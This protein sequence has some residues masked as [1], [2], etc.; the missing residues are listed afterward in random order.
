[1]WLTFCQFAA[2]I[3]QTVEV[4]IL[5][6]N[7]NWDY[8]LYRRSSSN[9]AFFYSS[10]RLRGSSPVAQG[11]SLLTSHTQYSTVNSIPRPR[12]YGS[13]ICHSLPG[14]LGSA[15]E[16]TVRS[17]VVQGTGHHQQLLETV[18]LPGRRWATHSILYQRIQSRMGSDTRTLNMRNQWAADLDNWWHWLLWEMMLRTQKMNCGVDH[19]VQS[20]GAWW[21]VQNPP[22][23]CAWEDGSISQD[24]AVIIWT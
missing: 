8:P 12:I 9:C 22:P 4:W 13:T 15:Q 1:M 5:G 16:M 2:E 20:Q 6:I 23:S 3:W 18:T 17:E 7:K 11:I 24:F 10:E 21:V 14:S 19:D